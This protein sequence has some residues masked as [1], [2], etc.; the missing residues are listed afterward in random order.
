[1]SIWLR[2]T[3]FK[4]MIFFIIFDIILSLTTLYMAYT[5]RFNFHIP[6]AFLH[7]FWKTFIM[8][9][10]LKISFLYIFKNYFIVWRF[11]GFLDAKNIIK[12]HIFAYASFIIVYLLSQ[13]LSSPF[14]RSV[15]GID[16]SLLGHC[17]LVKE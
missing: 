11:F 15:I 10:M 3:A 1:M 6:E 9:S 13:D 5:F 12:A 17:A 2:P 7:S 16:L 4:R 8:L 14:P